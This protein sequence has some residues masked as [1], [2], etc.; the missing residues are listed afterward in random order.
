MGTAQASVGSSPKSP[1]RVPRILLGVCLA[2]L[3]VLTAVTYTYRGVRYPIGGGGETVAIMNS[4]L[5]DG[6]FAN[7]FNAGWTGPSAFLPP[8]YPL[9]R[10][11]MMKLFGPFGLTSLI[12]VTLLMHGL[13]AALLPSVSRLLFSRPG[14]GIWGALLVIALPLIDV[15]H[16]D[17]IYVATG[18]LIFYL[19]AARVFGAGAPAGLLRGAALGLLAALLLLTNP[20][21][22]LAFGP[23]LIALVWRRR[24]DVPVRRAA[25]GVLIA[26]CLGCVP[27]TIRNYRQF[28]RFIFIRDNFGLVLYS[29]NNDCA[30]PTLLENLR[31]GCND[32]VHPIVN[33]S[34]VELIRRLGEVEYNRNR[35]SVALAWIRREPRRF[36][37]LTGARFV[38]FWF[39]SEAYS[40]WLITAL[41]I[42]G[43]LWMVGKRCWTGA[44]LLA[45]CALYPLV[46][47]I[48]ETT[49]RYRYPIVWV[50]LLQAGYF[51]NEA[52][53]RLRR[54]RPSRALLPPARKE[55]AG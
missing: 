40:F 19:C 52:G 42:P 55:A 2:W 26:A 1:S 46:F 23:W 18:I 5:R 36:L 47:Y 16:W 28:G 24:F 50:S 21:S 49:P 10:A 37:E 8:L 6:T 22:A 53:A 30:A 4:L 43:A 15:I 31:N 27:W 14:P 44:V 48:A 13:H 7:P 9:F 35:L 29:S 54:L 32:R 51:L 45:V 33:T 20:V 12:I 39:P 11:G 3:A 25:A 41:S 38:E 34:E 17:A